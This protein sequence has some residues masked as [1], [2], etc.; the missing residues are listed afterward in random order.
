MTRPAQVETQDRDAA[1][2][3]LAQHSNEPERKLRTIGHSLCLDLPLHMLLQKRYR[4]LGLL[5]L[6][7]DEF[8]VLLA[9]FGDATTRGKGG[10]RSA[11]R[12]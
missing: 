11:N 8:G 7:G 5:S 6:L 4:I 2:C 12:T 1:D 10:R 9:Q 3:Q